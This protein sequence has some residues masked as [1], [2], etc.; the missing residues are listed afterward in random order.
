MRRHTADPSRAGRTRLQAA[1]AILGVS[2]YLTS[3]AA[4]GPDAPP[5]FAPI[6]DGRTLSG[7]H[8]SATNHHGSTA[9][10]RVENAVLIG[11]QHPRGNGGL[12]LTNRAYHN[13]ELSLDVEPDYGCDGGIFLR[14]DEQGRA[15]QVM[16][17]YL[18]G[19]NVGG[20]YGE[21][22]EHVTGAPAENWKA[23]WKAGGWNSIRARIEGE[24]PRIQ[25]WLNGR[26]IMD[27]TDTANHAA[28][29]ATF[30]M[31]GLQVHGGERWKEG[32]VHRFRAV[33][34]KELP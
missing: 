10:W 3:R 4:S 22:L 25:V 11:T 13:V 30:G 28:G 15:Y 24:T 33:A 16:L 7:W 29:G 26:Q 20:I 31:I 2:L 14:S 32:G 18:D 27:W 8:I 1:V 21:G 12:L 17:D 19:G 9:E 6:F 5:G 23:H 34:V